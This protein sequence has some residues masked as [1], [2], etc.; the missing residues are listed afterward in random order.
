MVQTARGIDFL[1]YVN[2]S[3]N[4]ELPTWEKVGGQR[5]ASL[6][7]SSEQLETTN[8][9][10]GEWKSFEYGFKELSIS[11]EGI[12][13]I[14]DVAYSR[15]QQSFLNNEKVLVQIKDEAGLTY[16]GLCLIASMPLDFAYD[17]MVTW[18]CEL[19]GSGELKRIDTPIV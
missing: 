2:T 13:V 3:G 19:I 9:A 15:F 8:K 17:D 11:C 18:S 12:L 4:P 6:E 1:L 10:S 5:G 16:E 7:V 14:D